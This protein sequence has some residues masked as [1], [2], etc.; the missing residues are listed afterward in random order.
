M[1]FETHFANSVVK[2]GDNFEA[3]PMGF[4]TFEYSPK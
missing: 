1:G 4:E 2:I 3:V